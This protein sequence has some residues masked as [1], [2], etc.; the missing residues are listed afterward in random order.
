MGRKFNNPFRYT[1]SEDILKASGKVI[2]HIR[3]TCSHR[4]DEG[5]MMGVLIIDTESI[6][7][8]SESINTRLEGGASANLPQLHYTDEGKAFIAAYSGAACNCTACKYYKNGCTWFV[9]EIFDICS[10]ESHFKKEE[11]V[12][13]ALNKEI[14]E[15]KAGQTVIHL[16]EE[17]A[18]IQKEKEERLGRERKRMAEAKRFRQE[19]RAGNCTAEEHEALIRESQFEKAEFRRI[20]LGFD[21][22]INSLNAEIDHYDACLNLLYNRRKEL[23]DNLQ[24]WTFS[25]YKVLNAN[26]MQDNILNI[27]KNQGLKPPGGTGD[28]AGPKLLQF[29]FAKG[30]EP[31]SMGEFWYGHNGSLRLHGHFYPSC[32]HKCGPLLGYMLEGLD[33]MDDNTKNRTELIQKGK[34]EEKS[35]NK[36]TDRE[37]DWPKEHDYPSPIV[38]EDEQIIAVV[39]HFG[40]L[41]LP[42]KNGSLSLLER[43]ECRYGKLYPVHRLDMDTSGLIIFAKDQSTQKAI[44]RQFEQEQVSKTYIAKLC[45]PE[46]GLDNEN[47]SKAHF[48]LYKAEKG[49]IELPIAENYTDR[50]RQKVD[51]RNGKTAVTHYEVLDIDNQEYTTIL[52]RPLTGKT[53]QLRIHSAHQDGLCRPI[54]GDRLY[55]G[56]TKAD[57]GELELFALDIEFVH[58]KTGQ[59]LFITARN[60]CQLTFFK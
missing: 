54:V 2:S 35:E 29:A 13:S 10:P 51:I 36:L 39:K 50:P 49:R 16:R 3:R 22:K 6:N 42:G 46:S 19:K 28:C 59:K 58:P 34:S 11:A 38:Y 52:F 57:C 21:R 15:A 30:M 5:K 41:S 55:G 1:P 12:I 37:E 56:C 60:F 27:F 45:P 32:T 4:F 31:V 18:E 43:L 25:Q 26:G 24:E 40:E 23:S 53:H 8:L 17:L 14:E 9:P 33:Y 47:I 48:T 7:T 44:Q 20:K